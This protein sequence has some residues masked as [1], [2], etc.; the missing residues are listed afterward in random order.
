LVIAFLR[1]LTASILLAAFL[2]IGG[3]SWK[4]LNWKQFALVL[5][6]GLTGIVAYNI[7][8]FNGLK[9]IEA[10]RASLI[11]ALNP[12]AIMIVAGL[13]GMER[14]T[15][16]RIAGILIALLGVWVVLSNGRVADIGES[17]GV[18]EFFILGCV[19]SWVAYTIIGRIMVQEFSPLQFTTYSS[20]AGCL[21]L[22]IPA[23]MSMRAGVDFRLDAI[24]AILFLGAFGTAMAFVWYYDGVKNLGPTRAGIFI[25]LVPVWGVLMS[26]ILLAEQIT[27][28]SISGGIVIL[29]GVL[30]TNR[31][32]HPSHLS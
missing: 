22:S 32:P 10:N 24:L 2:T 5:G 18:G 13:L 25:N 11:V 12:A 29:V 27:V 14:I 23:M 3:E 6:G 8:F 7:F 20:L 1:F 19:V 31:K 9:I 4:K 30:L 26:A 28:T 15:S 16:Q 21:G 17:L